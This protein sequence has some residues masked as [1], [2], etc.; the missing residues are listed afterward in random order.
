[1]NVVC[2][3]NEWETYYGLDG[4][5]AEPTHDYGD[6]NLEDLVPGFQKVK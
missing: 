1:M 5:L 3:R 6:R 2:D 4:M